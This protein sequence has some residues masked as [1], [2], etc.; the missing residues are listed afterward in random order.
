MTIAITAKPPGLERVAPI[1]EMRDCGRRA[2]Y[3]WHAGL[4]PSGMGWLPICASCVDEFADHLV[5][6]VAPLAESAAPEYLGSSRIGN[7]RAS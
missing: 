7:A 3:F 1:C 2:D 5:I 4:P 6:V